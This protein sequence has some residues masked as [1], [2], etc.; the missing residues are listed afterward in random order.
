MNETSDVSEVSVNEVSGSLSD[1]LSSDDEVSVNEA[2]VVSEVSVNEVS[3]ISEVSV[4]K[5]SG[6]LTW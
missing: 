3:V 1:V 6:S 5:A 2:S 4:N